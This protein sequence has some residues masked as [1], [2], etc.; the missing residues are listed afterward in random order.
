VEHVD[1][2]ELDE[3]VIAA[4]KTF[5]LAGNPWADPRAHLHITDG[6]KF[7]KDAPSGSYDVIIQDSSDP[8]IIDSDGSMV[9]LPSA[10]L[11]EESHFRQ[12]HRILTD[13]G[14]LNIQV[15]FVFAFVL[16]KV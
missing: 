12:I 8:W 7:V 16:A 4:C 6:A 11:F 14:I 3:E 15:S 9:I 13:D 2:V 5:F 10:V 1:H